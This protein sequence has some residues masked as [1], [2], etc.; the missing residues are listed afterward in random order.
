MSAIQTAMSAAVG[1]AKR[2][3]TAR[4]PALPTP[5]RPNLETGVGI[6]GEG[7]VG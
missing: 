2:E 1:H 5:I 3:T 6:E 4:T 7:V